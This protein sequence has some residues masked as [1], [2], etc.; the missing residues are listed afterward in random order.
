[1]DVSLAISYGVVA[2]GV[3]TIWGVGR[4]FIRSPRRVWRVSG[5]IETNG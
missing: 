2:M 5:A 3:R 1:M 4:K